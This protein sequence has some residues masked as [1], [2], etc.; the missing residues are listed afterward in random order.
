MTSNTRPSDAMREQF[1]AWYEENKMQ[2]WLMCADKDM[3]FG[4]WQAAL[5]TSAT[6]A[7]QSAAPMA[8]EGDDDIQPTPESERAAFNAMMRWHLIRILQAWRY[9][10]NLREVG[11]AAFEWARTNDVGRA[12]F[13]ASERAVNVAAPLP[14]ASE[15]ADEAVTPMTQEER[16]ALPDWVKNA[17]PPEGV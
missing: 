10:G 8:D 5:E 7:E 15:Q 6:L 17:R 2:Y 1:E 16:D 11:M 14:R 9:G 13:E 12:A 3:C 4:I